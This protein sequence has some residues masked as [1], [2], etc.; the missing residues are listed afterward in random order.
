[1]L[2]V[3]D[4]RGLVFATG[5]GAGFFGGDTVS[6]KEKSAEAQGSIAAESGGIAAADPF[7]NGSVIDRAGAVKTGS[8]SNASIILFEAVTGLC[9][10][11]PRLKVAASCVSQGDCVGGETT[12]FTSKD[13]TDLI[14]GA[15]GACNAGASNVATWGF[16]GD[17]VVGKTA[18]FIAGAIGACRERGLPKAPWGVQGDWVGG[19]ATVFIG[20]V[21]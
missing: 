5:C 15:I 18:G 12:A 3:T 21:C 9:S 1:M 16:H 7:G 4:F 19:E 17:C 10:V 2:N 20:E 13:S 6:K 8:P 14:A 11:G